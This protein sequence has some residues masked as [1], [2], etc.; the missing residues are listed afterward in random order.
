MNSMMKIGVLVFAGVCLLFSAASLDA[1]DDSN[2]E[3]C[4]PI[5]EGLKAQKHGMSYTSKKGKWTICVASSGRIINL[6]M[7]CNGKIINIPWRG[8]GA[9]GPQWEGVK[10]KQVSKDKLAFEGM[11][12]P[13]KCTL[14]YMDDDGKLM[15]LAGLQNTKDREI[16][17]QKGLRLRLGI[18]HEMSHVST[19][20]QT[21]FPT[22]MRCEKDYYWGYFQN[23]NGQ[24]LVMATQEP[25]AS[26]T[27]HCI[28]RNH[29]ISTSSLEPL[30]RLPLP[31]RH[32]QNLTKLGPNES[33]L[34]HITLQ[35][36]NSLDEVS[37]IVSGFTGG[38]VFDIKQ[39]V[40]EPGQRVTMIVH[41][42]APL[43]IK[44]SDSAGGEIQCEVKPT[45]G[46]SLVNFDA[47]KVRGTCKL[48]AS[49]GNKNSE[50]MADTEA[51]FEEWFKVMVDPKTGW[52]YTTKPTWHTRPQNGSWMIGVLVA[53]YAATGREEHLETASQW[54]DQFLKR[55][56]KPS[57]A[58]AGYT[59]ISEAAKFLLQLAWYERFLAKDKPVWKDRY[60]KHMT[61]IDK[62]AAYLYKIQDL[63]QTEG[64]PTYEDTQVG[65]SFCLLALHAQLFPPSSDKRDQFLAASETIRRRHACLRQSIIPDSRMRGGTLRFWEAQYDVLMKP[66][67]MSSPHA[68]T[69][70]SVW[71]TMNLYLLTGNERYLT[72][73]TDAIGS[74]VQAIH[75][76]S[77]KIRWA[78]V[79]DPY[80]EASVFVENPDKPGTGIRK[81]QI[82]GEQWIPM[83]SDWWQPPKGVVAGV[84]GQG[85]SCD[86]DVHEHFRVLAEMF[87]PNAFVLE[88][89]DGSIKTWNCKVTKEGDA[90][91]V[92]PSEECVTRIHLNLSNNHAIKATFASGEKIV[93][94]CK[95]MQWIGPGMNKTPAPDTYIW[96][97]YSGFESK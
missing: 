56:Q 15:I 86:N 18:H 84:R 66:N 77:G 38:P 11:R 4:Q 95:G 71:G 5:A 29:R 6:S 31:K 44:A 49:S 45:E 10:F 97:E 23:P 83:I 17:P 62:A 2:R 92:T 22:L 47:P 54:A 24:I 60:E 39:T 80:I 70:R 93:T 78:F 59:A 88:R 19:Y 34:W 89:K 51:Q 36:A 21:F 33:K 8:D 41:H 67:M 48:L 79:P 26:H 16:V 7:P 50:A 58:V 42:S 13:I 14:S 35:P 87:I 90:L 63:S 61:A 55:Y 1:A 72:E 85:W 32:P 53:R 3:R 81:G 68:W 46:G 74:C 52:F 20:Y 12:G 28:G 43:A 57:G 75:P 64:Q 37:R 82:I 65:S 73:V 40:F 25:V 27:I 9:N 96:Q 76:K 69:M 94:Q 91:V 30:H